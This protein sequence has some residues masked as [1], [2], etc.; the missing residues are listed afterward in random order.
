MKAEKKDAELQNIIAEQKIRTQALL[1]EL[2]ADAQRK[3]ELRVQGASY[4]QAVYE[5]KPKT[6]DE[7]GITAKQSSTWQQIASIPKDELDEFIAEKKQAVNNAFAELFQDSGLKPLRSS[8]DSNQGFEQ[9]SAKP[10][11]AVRICSV[12]HPVQTQV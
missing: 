6:L 12:P 3:G 9:R 5:E 4:S 2:L 10:F 7:I 11:T 1:G 8:Q